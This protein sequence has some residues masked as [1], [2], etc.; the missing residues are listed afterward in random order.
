MPSIIR[1]GAAF[2]LA[3]LSLCPDTSA[4]DRLR[5]AYSALNASQSYLWVAQDL[6]L[7]RKH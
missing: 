4:A 6:G 3:F 5:V 2:L 7:Y 1:I